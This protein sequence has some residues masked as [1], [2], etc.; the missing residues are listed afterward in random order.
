[1]SIQSWEHLAY[2]SRKPYTK[3]QKRNLSISHLG[4]KAWNKGIKF[5]KFSGDNHPKWKGGKPF[6]IDCGQRV[7]NRYAKRCRKCL[8]KYCVEE[9][10]HNWKGGY[11]NTI[12]RLRRTKKYYEWRRS[13][14]I[15][16]EFICQEC[17]KKHIY[18]EAHHIKKFADYPELRFD[19]N[20]GLTL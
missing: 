4:Q 2:D 1:M 18:I 14:F 17:G 19:I 7:I 13:I 5:P 10:S 8:D 15:R 20:N 3:E 12:N 9:N 11:E 16:D 6:C